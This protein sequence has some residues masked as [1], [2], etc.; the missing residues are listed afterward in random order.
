MAEE[1]NSEEQTRQLAT[2][3][4]LVKAQGPTRQTEIVAGKPSGS[5]SA[6]PET[7]GQQ[8]TPTEHGSLGS[9]EGADPG[10][11]REHQMRLRQQT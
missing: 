11:K 10:T 2:W 6:G 5:A 7:L 3:Q 9:E 8:Q 1:E 4:E